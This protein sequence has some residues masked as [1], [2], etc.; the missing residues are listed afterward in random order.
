LKGPKSN[1]FNLF[2]LTGLSGSGKSTALKLFED[3]GYYCV[4]NLPAVLI[5]KF[6]E[7][8]KHSTEEFSKVALCLDTRERTFF[9]MLPEELLRLKQN[10]KNVTIIF[11]DCDDEAILRRYSETR[12]KHPIQSVSSIT[13]GIRKERKILAPLRAMADVII[14][15]TN[16]NSHQLRKKI[17][18]FI[19]KPVETPL[20]INLISF[21][22]R[23]GIPTESDI[24]MDVRFL[25][26]PFFTK[27]LRD[28]TG[29]DRRVQKYMLRFK[30]TKL[31]LKKWKDFLNTF[32]PFYINEGKKYMTISVGCTGG[33]HRSVAIVEMIKSDIKGKGF[34]LNVKHRDINK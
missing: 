10:N 13:E 34:V 29:L 11:L 5:N 8:C 15:T 32:I 12:R 1:S 7:L 20:N 26:N 30:E 28:L 25:P 27:N 3:S 24:V 19:K 31:F 21:G 23:Y 22:Y 6:I 2:I 14:D 9:K 4:D 33:V 16:M 17:S 18:E